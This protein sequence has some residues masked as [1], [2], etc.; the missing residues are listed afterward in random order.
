M[1]NVFINPVDFVA[2][3]QRIKQV[4]KA[5]GLTV[6][7]FAEILHV[8]DNAVYKWQRGETAPDIL[9]IGIISSRFG[10][11]LDYLILG[12]GGDDE[13]SPLDVLGKC[14]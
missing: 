13:S 8:S 3:G 9:N 4:R 6:E 5:N 11:S 14:A 1:N 2:M 10:V 7:K 12:R